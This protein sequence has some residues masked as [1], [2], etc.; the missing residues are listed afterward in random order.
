MGLRRAVAGEGRLPGKHKL[1]GVNLQLLAD[2]VGWLVWA[3]P[4]LPGPVH[5]L[6][7]ARRVGLIDALSGAGVKTFADKGYQGVGARSGQRSSG[8]TIG[9]GCPAGNAT[10]TA[11]TPA[12]APAANAPSRP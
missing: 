1:H 10:S 8:I 3:S 4:A 7:A 12:S 6:S 5:D 11:P 2:P 9:P